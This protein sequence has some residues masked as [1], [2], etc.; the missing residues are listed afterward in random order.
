MKYTIHYTLRA[1]GPDGDVIE[2]TVPEEPF[3]FEVG[4]DEILEDLEE[5]VKAADVG[6]RFEVTIPA[7]R[8]YGPEMEG[9]F[10]VLPKTQFADEEGLDDSVMAEGE[11]VVM[12]DETGE[13]LHGVVTGVTQE[14]VEV[15]FNHPLAGIDLHFT[16]QLMGSGTSE[17]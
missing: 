7:D 8:A 2:A 12:R 3:T 5:A 14:E 15:D 11:V 10:A 9:A 13:E 6:D 4:T 16:I 17:G 1:D